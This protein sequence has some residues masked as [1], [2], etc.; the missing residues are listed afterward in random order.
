MHLATL[1]RAFLLPLPFLL[2]AAA[3]EGWYLQHRRAQGY[4]WR[5]RWL[6]VFWPPV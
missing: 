4:D 2:L 1:P 3:L 5:A 6:V